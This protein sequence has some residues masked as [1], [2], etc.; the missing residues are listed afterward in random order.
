MRNTL[1][2]RGAVQ[3]LLFKWAVRRRFESLGLWIV[4]HLPRALVYW[5]AIRVATYRYGGSPD[6][7]SVAQM[8]KAWEQ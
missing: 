6:E 3:W 4:W 5:S 8:L 7:R 1:R 2:S